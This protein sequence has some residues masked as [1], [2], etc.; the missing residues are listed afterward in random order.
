MWSHYADS[1]KGVCLTFDIEKDLDFFSIPYK[2]DYLSDYPLINLFNVPE[3]KEVQLVLATKSEEWAYE[4]EIRI[5]KNKD[6]MPQ[7]RD[8]IAFNPKAL[9]EIKFGYK[10]SDEQIRTIMNLVTI[11]YPHVKFYTSKI[12][13]GVFGI[14]FYPIN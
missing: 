6:N 5:V 8:A 1:H 9:T 14:E 2:V 7:Y 3:K 12:K 10:S 4:Q 13:T 11:K